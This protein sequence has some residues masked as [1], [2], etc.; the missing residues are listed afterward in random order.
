[1]VIQSGNM[2][3]QG[4]IITVLFIFKCLYL[5]LADFKCIMRKMTP[6]VFCVFLNTNPIM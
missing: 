6:N 1:M 5:L 4:G 2:V 3:L